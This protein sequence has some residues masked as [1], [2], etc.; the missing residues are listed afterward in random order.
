MHGDYRLDNCMVDDDGEVVAVLDWE[1]CTLGDPLADV[2]LLLVY[3]TGPGRRAVGVDRLGHDR[4]RLPRPRPIWSTATPRSRG[5]DL[6]QLDF[7]VAFAYWKLACILEGVYARYL[8]GALGERDPAELAPFKL[9]VERG[10]ARRP[11]DA[12][13][14]AA[15]TDPYDVLVERRPTLDDAGAG[16]DAH[17]LDRR[18]RRGATAVAEVLDECGDARPLATLRRR[19]LHRLPGP[20]ADDGAAR[21]R[22][23]RARCGPTIELQAGRDV[24]GHDVLLLT[25]PEPDIGVAPLRRTRSSTWPSS[26]ACAQMVGL[27]AYPFATP[28]TRAATAVDARAVAPTWL[29][30]VP[31]LENSVDVPAGVSAAL[32]HALHADGHARR[33]GIWAQVPHYVARDGVPGGH[34]A[35]LDGLHE[36]A[37][38]VVDADDLRARTPTHPAATARRARRRQRRARGDARASS[39][40]S[41]TPHGETAGGTGR[42]QASS[43]RT[44]D[45]LAAELERFLRDQDW[46]LTESDHERTGATD[47]RRRYGR[48]HEGRR[49]HRSDLPTRRRERQELEAAGYA[50]V[51]TAETAT[52]RSSRCCS[53]PSTPTSSSSARRSRSPSPATR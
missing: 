50:G 2:G 44:G 27:G 43:C 28:H 53:P 31:F 11:T 35:L 9:Q 40:S 32:E 3:W 26:S 49:R 34:V 12:L 51:W 42:S 33:S 22:Q 14:R 48:R 8:G 38:I 29:A 5:R 46:H 25:G 20:P 1:I 36:V 41:T 7:Y 30:S 37:G 19:H 4:A 18:Q 6:A 17:R 23:H 47:D 13:E 45:E 21:R 16:R 39:R 15:M 10:R 24:D 52:T